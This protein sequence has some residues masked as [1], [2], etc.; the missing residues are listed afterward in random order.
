MSNALN[1]RV[2]QNAKN[3]GEMCRP[4]ETI[5]KDITVWT[6]LLVYEDSMWIIL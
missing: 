2:E 5:W 1:N 3:D 6:N 4:R